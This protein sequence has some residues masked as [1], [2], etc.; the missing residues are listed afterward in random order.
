MRNTIALLFSATAAFTAVA[1]ADQPT[2][3]PQKITVQSAD[4]LVSVISDPAA[5]PTTKIVRASDK[6]VLWEIP[7]WHGGIFVSKDGKHVVVGNRGGFI[8]VEHSE[9]MVLFTFWGEGAKIREVTLNEFLSD[10]SPLLRT[11]SHYI[12]GHIE[13]VDANGSLVVRDAA[14][15][16][17]RYDMTTGRELK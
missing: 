14:E 13:K 9:K 2:P 5:P 11:M 1:K 7:G 16:V 10:K 12:W 4:G 15:K 17:F 6:K 3:V 8:P